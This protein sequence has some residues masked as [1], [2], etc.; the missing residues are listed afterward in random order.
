MITGVICSQ[1]LAQASNNILN[2]FSNFNRLVTWNKTTG[3]SNA[4]IVND[5]LGRHSYAGN[6]ALKIDFTGTGA[7]TFDGGGDI[8]TTGTPMATTIQRTGNYI[9]SY[10]FDKSNVNTDI[11]FTVLMYVNGVLASSR[12]IEQDLFN[13]SGFVDNQWNV[14]FQ[15][16]A[17]TYGDVVDFAFI[18]QS[19]TTG[20]QLYMDRF[21]LEIDNRGGGYPT[22]YTEAPLD[23]IEEENTIVIP[24]IPAGDS[25][26][27]T[28]SIT[29]ARIND[30]DKRNIILTTEILLALGLEVYTPAVTADDVFKFI[31]R[32]PT[33]SDINPGSTVINAKII[34]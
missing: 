23:I 20:C 5:I 14:Y 11:V 26:T 3:G 19:D 16:F 15:N 22:I 30:S 1:E 29:G 24:N 6:G 33:G 12:T 25:I 31:V 10:A 32:N 18:A 7:V 17:L 27:I 2:E 13:T 21:K 8:T 34:R 4:N 9:L 28:G